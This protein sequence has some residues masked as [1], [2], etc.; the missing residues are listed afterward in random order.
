LTPELF[1]KAKDIYLEAVEKAGPDRAAFL[2]ATCAG[3]E[4]LRNEVES[5]LAAA[6]NQDLEGVVRAE[7]LRLG[8][9][10]PPETLLPARIGPYEILGELGHGGMGAVYLGVLRDE[11][12][13]R[14]VALKVVRGG[15]GSEFLRER[16]HTERR[17]L[18]GLE[19][20][21]IARL[22]DGGTTADGQPW[23]AME[24]VEGSHLVEWA[25]RAS[26]SREARIR[27]FLEVCEAVQYAHQH[28]VVHRDL[29][30]GNILVSNDGTP[31]LLDF[32]L[33]KLLDVPSDERTA[34]EHRLLTPE[35]AS[36]EQVRGERITTATDVYSLG[37]VLYRLLTGAL[38]YRTK[39]GSSAD[40]QR[41]VVDQA[42]PSTEPVLG[43]D[44]DTV[45]RKALAKEPE[46]RYPT[47]QAFAEDLRRH[48]DGRPVLARGDSFSYR[49]GKFLRR[50]RLAAA[51]AFAVVLSLAAGAGLAL[52]QA[53]R[54]RASEEV[55]R[56][57]FEEVRSLAKTVL[58][59]LH[60]EIAPL[61]GSTK[62]RA[63][64][65]S[66]ALR[67]LDSLAA[68]A[69]SDPALARDVAAGYAR[70]GLVQGGN[71][72][73]LGDRGAALRSHQAAIRLL[74]PLAGAPAAAA[75]DRDALAAELHAAA[76]LLG[77]ADPGALPMH[78]R[79]LALRQAIFDGDP[80]SRDAQ[81]AL[82][83][84]CSALADHH[85]YR[86]EWPAAVAL[87]ERQRDLFRK[88]A[89]EATA[90]DDDR[91]NLA[92]SDK[93]LGAVLEYSGRS[94]EAV[95]LYTEAIA[96]DEA[97][98][99][100]DPTSALARMDLSFSL[101]ALGSLRLDQD[102][103]AV[104]RT[105]YL[106]ALT[107][108]EAV[109]AADPANAWAKSG[110]ARARARLAEIEERLGHAEAAKAHRATGAPHP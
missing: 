92:L 70:L 60:D 55:A 19:H 11:G 39:T 38:P 41:A 84:S 93:T 78:A 18:S 81:R 77:P 83:R 102:D 21:N 86:K 103:L 108:R 56:K 101:G 85:S 33:A 7:A 3:E 37:V 95:P 5:L 23:F 72:A 75:A 57:R 44:L 15:L 107:L 97:R 80:L 26:L 16:F 31:K 28:L 49:A 100:A 35:Y 59:E 90:T 6:E 110:V 94:V 17:I 53:A 34:T 27:L 9:A 87:R 73:T 91:R 48:L 2:A 71:N 69:G 104:S 40:L 96:L 68:G 66:T 61:P 46:R 79:G 99:A 25:D 10:S 105:L 43:A 45:L 20:P 14:R 24:L 98:T 30:P 88:I 109:A 74:E 67:Y 42:P 50:H 82:A 13:E 47:V 32:G 8:D 58:F 76:G 4:S 36:P 1:R 64:L 63:V 106:R 51:A 12:L 52:W 29:K 22:Y 65:V 62:A 54:A 89:G